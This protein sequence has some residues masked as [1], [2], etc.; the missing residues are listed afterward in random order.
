MDNQLTTLELISVSAFYF[1]IISSPFLNRL[2]NRQLCHLISVQI[3]KYLLFDGILKCGKKYP[4]PYVQL[5]RSRPKIQDNKV[6]GLLNITFYKILRLKTD[7]YTESKVYYH[8]PNEFS[9]KIYT[10]LLA[11]L[12]IFLFL[13]YLC[14]EYFFL[15][16]KD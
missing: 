15:A 8:Y 9:Y 7:N 11:F 3:V 6:L 4:A 10:I 12:L 14:F 2:I 1:F 13:F 16:N 5:S